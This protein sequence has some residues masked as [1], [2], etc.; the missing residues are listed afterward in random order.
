MG[1]ELFVQTADDHQWYITSENDVFNPV[2]VTNQKMMSAGTND[3]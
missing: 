2:T 1:T 3:D